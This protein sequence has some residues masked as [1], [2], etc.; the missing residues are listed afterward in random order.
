MLLTLRTRQ[1]CRCLKWP[2]TSR[3]SATSEK[4]RDATPWIAYHL[5]DNPLNAKFAAVN[6]GEAGLRI[7]DI[8][9]PLTPTEVAYLNQGVPVHAGVSY[10]DCARGLIYISD[11]GGFKVLQV[12]PQV[13]ARLGL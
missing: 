1:G 5:I 13:R 3:S 12:Q 11:T 6:F 4:L 7:F 8:R 9:D 2:S 10:Y